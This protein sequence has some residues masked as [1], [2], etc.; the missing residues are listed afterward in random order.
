MRIYIKYYE[1]GWKHKN[2]A[3]H[4]VKYQRRWIIKWF[5]N[6]KEA[7]LQSKYLQIKLFVLSREIAI[8]QSSTKVLKK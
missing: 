8:E 4:D 5:G 3:L 7:V 1:Q 2:S 6:E